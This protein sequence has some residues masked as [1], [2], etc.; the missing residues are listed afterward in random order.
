MLYVTSSFTKFSI[1]FFNIRLTGLTSITWIWVHR[2]FFVLVLAYAL[3]A[4]F[5]LTLSC[6]PPATIESLVAVGKAAPNIKCNKNLVPVSYALCFLHP[7]FDWMLLAVPIIILFQLK[8]SWQKKARCIT[9]LAIGALSA[10]GASRRTYDAYHPPADMP[11]KAPYLWF[12][13]A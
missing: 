4:L 11:C 1:I 12:H 5:W 6:D 7:I 3:L 13:I 2:T 8:M 9:P 10:I